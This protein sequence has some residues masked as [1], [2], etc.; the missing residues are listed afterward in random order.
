MKRCRYNIKHCVLIKFTTR[1]INLYTVYPIVARAFLAWRP[2]D[3]VRARAKVSYIQTP[4]FYTRYP[5]VALDL[6]AFR[7]SAR[8]SKGIL[9]T[10]T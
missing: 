2:L 8:A 9:H 3:R 6:M 1:A 5:N 4:N 10:N 7:S